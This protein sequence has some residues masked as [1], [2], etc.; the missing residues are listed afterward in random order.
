MSIGNSNNMSPKSFKESVIK[1]SVKNSIFNIDDNFN[2]RRNKSRESNDADPQSLL[3]KGHHSNEH[4][5]Y[6]DYDSVMGAHK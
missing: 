2:K 1:K 4:S 5:A 6:G 3:E